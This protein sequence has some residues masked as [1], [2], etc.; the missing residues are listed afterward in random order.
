M[1]RRPLAAACAAFAI[2]GSSATC[3]HADRV[4]LTNGRIFEDIDA[5]VKETTVEIRLGGGVL[6]L[7]RDQVRSVE[8]GPSAV[9]DYA[10]RAARLRAGPVATA[11]DW[12][13]LARWSRSRGFDFGAREAALAAA[14]LDPDLAGLAPLLRALG[15]ERESDQGRWLP[16]TEAMRRRG[17]VE[18]GGEWVPAAVATARAEERRAQF[19]ERRRRQ[20]AARLERLAALAEI[21]VAQEVARAAAPPPPPLVIWG[22]PAYLPIYWGQQ[23]GGPPPASPPA[24]D[25]AG[26]PPRHADRRP[27]PARTSGSEG[28][29]GRQPGSLIPLPPGG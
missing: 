25:G 20:E 14:E 15:Y 2:A 29:L 4:V 28:I 13:E 12:L 11:G 21:R 9:A 18:D 7:P 3:L 10:E 16:Y 6:S 1:L 26:S 22:V 27:P 23:P 19:E 17:W 5:V 8:P 24:A